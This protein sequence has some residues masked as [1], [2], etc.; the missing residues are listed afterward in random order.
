MRRAEPTNKRRK[1][2]Y[3]MWVRFLPAGPSEVGARAKERQS[4]ELVNI[5]L[6]FPH[7]IAFFNQAAPNF[8]Y[9]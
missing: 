6:T 8:V 7:K 9:S 4:L 5:D 3:F 2:E 1:E